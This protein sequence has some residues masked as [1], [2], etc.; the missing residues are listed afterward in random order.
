MT[1]NTTPPLQIQVSG[2]TIL[3]R[4]GTKPRAEDLLKIIQKQYKQI[5]QSTKRVVH[6]EEIL[7][8][9]SQNIITMN[10]SGV[11]RKKT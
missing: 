2:N 8:I 6:L 4:Q 10:I 5:Y 7:K 1:A 9:H 3:D 11:L